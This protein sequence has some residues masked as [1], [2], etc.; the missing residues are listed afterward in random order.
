MK[1][2][3]TMKNVRGS[4]DLF[5]AALV[6]TSL[7]A[8]ACGSCLPA[9]DDSK[10]SE[11]TVKDSVLSL[12]RTYW[13]SDADECW[14]SYSATGVAF[15]FVGKKLDITFAGNQ[16]SSGRSN[17]R[18]AVYINGKR[19]ADVLLAAKERKIT[20]YEVEEESQ[21][22][23]EVRIIKLSEASESVAGIKK[24]T[25]TGVSDY[26][27]KPLANKA[28]KIEFIGD[29][30]T[31]GYGIDD[32]GGKNDATVGFLTSTED[33]TKTY[34]YKTAQALD[35]DYNIACF[36]GIGVISNVGTKQN[37]DKNTNGNDVMPAIYSQLGSHTHI[38]TEK[39]Q[40]GLA[41]V[42]LDWDFAQFQ[43]DLVVLNLGSNDVSYVTWGPT[44]GA[45]KAARGAEFKAGYLA[46]LKDIRAKNPNA[47]ILCTINLMVVPDDIWSL[48][49]EAVNAY[50]AE[51]GETNS[52]IVAFRL[53]A[54]NNSTD[55][56]GTHFHPS[57]VS[58][59]RAAK[60]LV[61][62]IERFMSWTKS[63]EVLDKEETLFA[64]DMVR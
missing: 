32:L 34:A 17:A 41:P 55:S 21:T 46:F 43:P 59:V 29:S 11:A 3:I 49:G 62:E 35:A 22:P 26:G 37:G 28:R 12:G 2:H 19:K 50:K 42:S 15:T 18:L 39:F 4:L 14:L 30:I 23:V 6:F 53:P 45:Y 1:E 61:T 8:L 38:G 58:N 44:W 31:A 33:V 13:T 47:K 5:F 64:A 54:M 51:T 25:L 48:I 57:E 9:G 20:V 60:A 36:S 56:Y 27:I 16:T 24:I 40:G 63:A 10:P 7:L 52:N